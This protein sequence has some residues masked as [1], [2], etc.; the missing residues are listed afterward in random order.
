MC[1]F[2]AVVVVVATVK[3]FGFV[4]HLVV[5]PCVCVC[6]CVY[7]EYVYD[8]SDRGIR[9]VRY[10]RYIYSGARIFAGIAYNTIDIYF[11]LFFFVGAFCC[12]HQSI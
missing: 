12:L 7:R 3:A 4:P 9:L 5:W 2:P 11:Y 6:V 1:T 10:F 8:A